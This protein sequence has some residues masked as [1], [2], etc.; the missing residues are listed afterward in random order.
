MNESELLFSLLTKLNAL[1]GGLFLLCA[2]GLVAIRQMLTCLRIYVG[3]ALLLAISAVILGYYHASIHLYVVAALT[4]ITKVF[5]IPWVLRHS[6][7]YDSFSKRE[8]S[9][10]LNIPTTLLLSAAI[11]IFAYYISS[12][13]LKAAAADVFEKVNLPIGMASLLI[14]AYT[15]T[16]RGEAV[17]QLLG[18]LAME[19]GAFFAGV[20]I[21]S[22]LPLI[23]EL[24]AAFY[25][26]ITVL[27][28]GLLAMR[29]HEKIAKT[30]VGEMMALREE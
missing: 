23:A 15:V 21:A 20:S 29:I 22:N 1:T 24:A 25:V 27:V 30:A 28:I 13:L 6:I 9:Q 7:G 3:Q 4:I 11:T 19:N 8:I 14:G 26:L 12:P 17:P 10:A 16:V 2:F 18:I 5:I